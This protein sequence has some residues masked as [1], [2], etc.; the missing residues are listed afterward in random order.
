MKNAQ[1]NFLKKGD[2][3]WIVSPAKALADNGIEDA[4]EILT[5]W[6]LQVKT[7]KHVYQKFGA[8]AGNDAQRKEDVQT[9]L[10]DSQAKAIFFA[11][12]GYGSIRILHQLNWEKFNQNPK[13]LV[14]FSDITYFHLFANWQLGL[15]SLH[16]TMPL[17]INHEPERKAAISQ[18]KSFLFGE[19]NNLNF[20][21]NT[22]NI[23]GEA[24]GQIIGGNLNILHG[25]LVGRNASDFFK[26]K[27]LFIEDV[28]EEL[29][30]LDRMLWNLK[31]SGVLQN[32]KALL[33]GGFTSIKDTNNWFPNQTIED[34]ILGVFKPLHI[35]IAFAIKAGHIKNNNP[36]PMAF[37][38]DIEITKT[39]VKI[40]FD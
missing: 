28:G 19:L 26:D 29:Y 15:A 24:K 36:I 21:G 6:G 13:W 10:N 38:C 11:R 35:P 37:N 9:A 32:L 12:G 27:I 14:G 31:S 1:P 5:S 3:V 17:E 39:L 30:A 4:V 34:L 20:E 7:G 18:T 25:Y 33:V 2:V 22:L 23:V 16:G 40:N 8:F